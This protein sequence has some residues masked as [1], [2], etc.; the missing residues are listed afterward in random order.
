[1]VGTRCRQDGQRC[2][3]QGYPECQLRFH[4]RLVSHT[5]LHLKLRRGGSVR[6]TIVVTASSC[7]VYSA[8]GGYCAANG[9][10]RNDWLFGA[11]PATR[12]IACS[13]RGLLTLPSTSTFGAAVL[14]S[15]VHAF[16]SL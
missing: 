13:A 12:R 7:K 5:Y 4:E 8:G 1:L 11:Q 6:D 2:Q 3:S 9:L 15:F 10:W 16:R 14:L